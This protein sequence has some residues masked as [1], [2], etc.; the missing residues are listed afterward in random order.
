MPIGGPRISLLLL[1]A[2]ALSLGGCGHQKSQQRLILRS[3]VPLDA[4]TQ[5]EVVSIL[6][7]RLKLVHLVPRFTVTPADNDRIEIRTAD[8]D[9]AT[10]V[11]VRRLVTRPGT[12][13]FAELADARIH[14]N[15]ITDAQADDGPIEID[16]ETIAEWVPMAAS[17]DG[18]SKEI[19][20][21]VAETIH[22]ER[23]V[24]GHPITEYLVFVHPSSRLTE[25]CLED[26]RDARNQPAVSLWESLW[27]TIRTLGQPKPPPQPPGIAFQFSPQGSALMRSLTTRLSSSLPATRR[28]MAIIVDGKIH[29]APTVMA[30]IGERG[31]IEGFPA[32]EFDQLI[33]ALKCGRLPVSLHLD[34]SSGDS[35]SGD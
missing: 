10:L 24:N 31:I 16:S 26:I 21:S 22:R 2:L 1:I 29:A 9:E 34:E 17:E 32:A 13:E 8:V 20:G 3:D 15:I 28:R 18:R 30:T 7:Q 25:A 6:Q 5:A 11:S 27:R 23:K 12:L 35:P 4:A 33:A 14:A 19:G